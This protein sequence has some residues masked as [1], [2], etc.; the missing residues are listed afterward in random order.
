MST[1]QNFRIFLRIT[2]IEEL[3]IQVITNSQIGYAVLNT[4]KYACFGV[5]FWSQN[6]YFIFLR[7]VFI[8]I[9]RLILQ[10]SNLANYKD[11][12]IINFF[13]VFL[14]QI[15]L[16]YVK[17]MVFSGR[18]GFSKEK[19]QSCRLKKPFFSIN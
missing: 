3:L 4:K 16:I 15:A 10:G 8:N 6:F 18:F 12:I 11:I 13:I 7:Y 1:V 9:F 2:I 17:K 5:I 19:T 14:A